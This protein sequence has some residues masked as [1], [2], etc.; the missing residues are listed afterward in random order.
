MVARCT[1]GSKDAKPIVSVY[2]VGEATPIDLECLLIEL[3]SPL[4]DAVVSTSLS[5]IL[6]LS[7]KIRQLDG[8]L[9]GAGIKRI[10]TLSCTGKSGY[11]EFIS[12][13]A[14]P[15]A[16]IGE[17]FEVQPTVAPDNFTCDLNCVF[18]RIQERDAPYRLET[19]KATTSVATVNSLPVVLARR[20]FG[21][22]AE[23]VILKASW[24][25][26]T[27]TRL[28]PRVMW[29]IPHVRARVVSVSPSVVSE[30]D[31]IRDNP[32]ALADW[33][34]KRGT[35]QATIGIT[36]RFGQRA[37]FEHVY[38]YPPYNV[39][40][41]FV[42]E[43]NMGADNHTMNLA[44]TVECYQPKDSGG[45]PEGP[46]VGRYIQTDYGGLS[47]NDPDKTKQPKPL[48]IAEGES[49]AIPCSERKGKMPDA[50]LAKHVPA[51]DV[52]I[53]FDRVLPDNAASGPHF[54]NTN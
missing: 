31:K 26:T 38:L 22:A 18:S 6:N 29:V 5:Q 30:A 50:V 35:T 19:L 42:V 11:R 2:N 20:D 39:G 44:A 54:Y 12:N 46:I 9:N 24:G 21:H 41:I 49:A 34:K 10:A 33:L 17:S 14:K 25:D 23:L 28:A 45:V 13:L 37:V 53:V 36:S 1:W 52:F 40:T 48:M 27:T 16:N 51:N 43:P 7:E 4:A 47:W 3:P 32:K 15:G 8:I